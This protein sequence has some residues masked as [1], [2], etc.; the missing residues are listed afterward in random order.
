MNPQLKKGTSGAMRFRGIFRSGAGAGAFFA[1]ILVWGIGVGCFA[2]AMNNFFSD[3]CQIDSYERGWLEFFREMPGL[4]LVFILALLHRVS[5]WK[6]M[7]L[8]TLISMAGAA[9]LLI[10][11]GK[12]FIT[13]FIMIW[14]M[15]EHLVMPVRSSIAMQIAKPAHAGQSLGFLTGIMNFGTV[16]G[17]LIV[18]LIFFGGTMW[19]NWSEKALFN[20]LWILIAALMI[21]SAASTFSPDAP[22]VPSKRPRMCFRRKFGKFYA[23]E[24]IYGAR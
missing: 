6:I 12:I 1:S 10:P 17:S 20:F 3:I 8:G 21:A 5:D 13:A 16:A 24:L 11:S 15:G 19:L 4:A 22:N 14:S 18:A 9:L 7:R 2:A 23:L